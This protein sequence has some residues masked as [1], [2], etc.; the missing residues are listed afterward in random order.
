MLKEAAC[1]TRPHRLKRLAHRLYERLAATRPG[2]S[3]QPLYL[4]ERFFYGVEVRRVGRQVAQLAAPTFDQLLTRGPLCAERL[5]ITII[6][7]GFSAGA[8]TYS[9]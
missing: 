9:M 8:R 6:C 5:S 3:Q 1:I 7:P 4:G 2:T